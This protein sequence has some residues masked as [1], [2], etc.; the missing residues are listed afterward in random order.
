VTVVDRVAP[1]LAVA[2]T[3]IVPLPL[4]LA[5]PVTVSQLGS[6]AVALHEHKLPV[7]TEKVVDEAL[8][9]IDW[10]EGDRPY[11]HAAAPCVAVIV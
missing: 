1:L 5:P 3:V 9:A 8:E 10:L 2:D 11:V 4:P 7:V 6:P